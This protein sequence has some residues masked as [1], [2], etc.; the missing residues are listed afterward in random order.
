M[1]LKRN[2]SLKYHSGLWC[3][4]HSDDVDFW[5][6]IP[7]TWAKQH[8]FV[9]IYTSVFWPIQTKI[10]FLTLPSNVNCQQLLD[11]EF[12]PMTSYFWIESLYVNKSKMLFTSANKSHLQI[13]LQVKQC[14]QWQQHS[15]PDL[16][17]S[18]F[19]FPTFGMSVWP[20]CASCQWAR[21]SSVVDLV[22]SHKWHWIL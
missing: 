20:G 14:I 15:P 12:P 1:T 2:Y 21:I 4:F 11:L 13:Y 8:T 10:N 19:P 22:S 9:S 18:K 6:V 3:F 5:K 7:K 16:R 17:S